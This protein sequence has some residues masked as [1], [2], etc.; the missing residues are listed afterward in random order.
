VKIHLGMACSAGIKVNNKLKKFSNRTTLMTIKLSICIPTYN[1]ADYLG[2][3]LESIIG[4]A[5]DGVEI[6]ISDNASEDN[7]QEIVEQYQKLFP[8]ITYYCQPKNMGADYNYL[9]IVELAKGEYCWLFGS[10]DVMKPKGIDRVLAEIES[11][12]DIYLCNRVE[13]DL[14]LRPIKERQWLFKE[15]DDHV[16]NTSITNNSE[17][18]DY[19]NVS[20]SLGALFSYISAVIVRRK[21]WGKIKNHEAFIGGNYVHVFKLLSIVIN[22]CLLKYI[23][24]SLVLCRKDNDSFANDGIVSRSL[25]D[26]DGY[27]YLADH[28]ITDDKIIKIAFLQVMKREYPWYAILKIRSLINEFDHWKQLENKLLKFGYNQNTL[29]LC[30][31]FGKY[32]ILVGIALYL[33]RKATRCSLM[34]EFIQS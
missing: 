14:Y 9:K 15:I 16:F 18:I 6:V 10:D 8:R 1:R 25:L 4:Q 19:F 28:I 34:K 32:R 24:D 33:K 12:C 27:L 2:E 20:Q 13:C 11:G 21:M 5:T 30:D 3:T 31:K 26:F 7:T 23:K 29:A 22:G 17:L